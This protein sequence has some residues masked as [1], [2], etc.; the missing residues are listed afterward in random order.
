[1]IFWIIVIGIILVLLWISY[2]HLEVYNELV[3]LKNALEYKF[4]NIDIVMNRRTNT[5]LALAKIAKK[6]G[7]HEYDTIKETIES[8]NNLKEKAPLEEKVEIVN[9]IE[10]GLFK[11][12]AL[13]EKYPTLKADQVYQQIMG[14]SNVSE[15]EKNLQIVRGEYNQMV[16]LYNVKVQTF[17]QSIVAGFYGFKTDLYLYLGQ[18]TYEP[19]LM[20]EE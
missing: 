11:V 10:K 17:P 4:A 8:R 2:K 19:K 16:N 18:D 1:M 14:D 6:Y 7:S 5:I 20:F 12:N 13:F 9:A 3:A 15:V